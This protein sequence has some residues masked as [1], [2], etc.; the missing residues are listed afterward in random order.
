M[1]FKSAFAL[2]LLLELM[3]I[4][5]GVF[6]YGWT[7]EA[8]QALTRYSGR[9]SLAIFSVIFL[10]YSHPVV[11]AKRILSDKVFLVFAIAHGIHLFELLSYLYFSGSPIIPVRLAGGM[12]AYA[13]I[14]VM[15][16]IQKQHDD[17]NI[18]DKRFNQAALIYLYYVWFIFF[19]TY[20]PRVRGTLPN[21]G[22][23]YKEF[24]VLLGWV[25]IML[26]FKW[27]QL[28]AKPRSRS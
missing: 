25:S 6:N 21:V 28:L 11:S 24:V 4:L 23:S 18:T 22:G 27:S 13:M 2:I 17:Q 15:P 14:F 12:L 5:L 16:W 10:F 9:V 19:M 3:A 20:L 8:L 7:L 26:G 1:T